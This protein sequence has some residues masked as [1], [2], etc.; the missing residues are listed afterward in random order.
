MQLENPVEWP[1]N[2]GKVKWASSGD[3]PSSGAGG[4]EERST[5]TETVASIG[6]LM[7]S[8]RWDGSLIIDFLKVPPEKNPRFSQ[9]KQKRE[10]D[11]GSLM[12]IR[13]SQS[14]MF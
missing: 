4:V 8:C 1:I 3:I 13:V 9:T 6:K 2:R 14:Y 5:P 12:T 11:T 7:G 10:N